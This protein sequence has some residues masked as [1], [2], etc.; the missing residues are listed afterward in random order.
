VRVRARALAGAVLAVSLPAAPAAHAC[1]SAACSLATRMGDRR[2]EPGGWRTDFWVRHADEGR[3]LFGGRRVDEVWRRRVDLARGG[4]EPFLHRETDGQLDLAQLDVTRGLG[5]RVSIRVGLPLFRRQSASFLHPRPARNVAT[6][7]GDV[8]V[9]ADMILL[10]RPSREI[11]VG[12]TLK[13]PT[14]ASALRGGDGVVDPMLQP[15]TGS[16]DGAASAQIARR[17]RAFSLSAAGSVLLTTANGHGY[18]R[19]REVVASVGALRPLHGRLDGTLLLKAQHAGRDRF[20]EAGVLA[21]G[22]SS[23][24]A[25]VGA[26]LRLSTATVR[27]VIQVPAVTRVNESQRAAGLTVTLGVVKAF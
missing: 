14:G 1:D 18:R 5:S 20:H 23:V 21:S 10:S 19:G 9:G 15:G 3:A 13:L 24:Q 7:V 12:A 4:F 22:Y 27:A 16:W 26:R 11:T 17:V 25:G 8:Q 6:G 2:L